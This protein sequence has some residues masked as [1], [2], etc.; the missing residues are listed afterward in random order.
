MNITWTDTCNVLK[1]CWWVYFIAIYF[2]WTDTCNVLK[3]H[4]IEAVPAILYLEPIHVMYWN[5]EVIFLSDKS[6]LLEPIHVMYWNDIIE[7]PYQND[8][9]WTDTCN[10]LKQTILSDVPSEIFLEPIHVMYWNN[11]PRLLHSLKLSWTDTCNVLKQACVL[12][13]LGCH[14]LEPIH[15]MYWNSGAQML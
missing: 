3:Q 14:K 5:S 1:Q 10:V 13:L 11:K 4:N 2:T 15:V 12:Y 7:C 8:L 6:A 9:T